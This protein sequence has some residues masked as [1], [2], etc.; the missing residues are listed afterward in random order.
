MAFEEREYQTSLSLRTRASIGKSRKAIM[1]QPCGSGK[2]TVAADIVERACNKDITCVFLSDRKEILQQTAR[3]FTAHGIDFGIVDASTKVIHKHKVYIGMVETFYRRYSAAK[4][5]GID[6]GLVVLDEAHMGNYSK[7]IEILDLAPKPPYIIGLT[8]TPISSSTKKPLNKLYN[9]IV[10]G[11]SSPWLIENKYLVPSIDFGQK[12]LYDFE[13][14]NGEFTAESQLKIFRKCKS[15]GK[16]FKLWE[17]KAKDRQTIIYNVTLEHNEEV[18]DLFRSNGYSCEMVSSETPDGERDQIT[19][20][21]KAGKIQIVCNVGIYTKGFDA[22]SISCVVVNRATDSLALWV[23]MN[24]GGRPY[25]NKDNFITIDMGNNILRHGSFNDEIDWEFLFKNDKRR[26]SDSIGN[27]YLCPTCYAYLMNKYLAECP[28][29]GDILTQD[30]IVKF[31]F[32]IPEE[33]KTKD[34]KLMNKDELKM[35]AKW[36]GYKPAWVFFTLQNR[37]NK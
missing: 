24:R 12:D 2:T 4:F 18:R 14:K 26:V 34:V 29:C 8:A 6:I 31:E 33:L 32:V 3:T 11:P 15:D 35:Y 37:Y 13:K 30:T 16:M 5:K 10:M 20:D 28:V 9:D 7:V 1:C 21:F 25:P 17:S 19:N 22:P 27:K 36:K 23:Q